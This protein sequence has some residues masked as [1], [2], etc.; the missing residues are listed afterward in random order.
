MGTPLASTI[1]HT[2]LSDGSITLRERDSTDQIRS[3]EDEVT[4]AV[5]NMATGAETWKDVAK[6]LP[7]F[8][9]RNTDE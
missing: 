5:K 3:S 4:N 6:R 7:S 1:D 8:A 9:A 2:T